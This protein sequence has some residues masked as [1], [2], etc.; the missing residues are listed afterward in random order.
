MQSCG[1]IT[2]KAVR[3]LISSNSSVSVSP[4]NRIQRQLLTGTRCS[5][6]A[7]NKI[8]NIKGA[9]MKIVSGTSSQTDGSDVVNDDDDDYAKQPDNTFKA[10][11]ACECARLRANFCIRTW[12]RVRQCATSDVRCVSTNAN[13]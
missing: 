3:A 8:A 4:I 11:S 6:I 10:V 12:H 13:S 7:E 9:E 2:R 1:I 5:C